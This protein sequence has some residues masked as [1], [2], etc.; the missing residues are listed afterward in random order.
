MMKMSTRR[1]ISKTKFRK[2]YRH[3]QQ[4]NLSPIIPNLKRLMYFPARLLVV[5]SLLRLSS[6]T[7]SL[8]V[9]FASSSFE[10]TAMS[11]HSASMFIIRYPDFLVAS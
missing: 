6:M 7:M 9:Y 11:L 4:C 1:T 5:S 10:F 2:I 3:R 8:A